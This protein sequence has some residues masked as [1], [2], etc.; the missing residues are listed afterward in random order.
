VVLGATIRPRASGIDPEA[1]N[2]IREVLDGVK[3]QTDNLRDG[4]LWT[5]NVLEELHQ[6]RRKRHLP[7]NTELVER[8]QWLEDLINRLAEAPRHP[9]ALTP[10]ESLFDSGSDILSTIRHHRERWEGLRQEPQTLI[11]PTRVRPRTSLDDMMGELLRPPQP[12]APPQIQP[13]PA[14]IPLVF[15]PDARGL[16]PRSA[17]LTLLTEFPPYGPTRSPLP[18]KA[19][20]LVVLAQIASESA[21]GHLSL[22]ECLRCDL[23]PQKLQ[24]PSPRITGLGVVGRGDAHLHFISFFHSWSNILFAFKDDAFTFLSQ[25][26]LVVLP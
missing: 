2:C 15:W 14:F 6:V 8:L 26:Y 20:G 21:P 9:K 17:S 19:S 23:L 7:D 1:L 3:A 13:P 16:R 10:V 24:T 18:C 4:Q 25:F 12:P 22:P 5:S 11:A